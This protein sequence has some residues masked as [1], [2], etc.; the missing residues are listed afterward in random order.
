[1]L[2]LIDVIKKMGETVAKIHNNHLVHGDLTTSNFLLNESQQIVVIDWGLSFVSEKAED[3]A[4][5]LYV[6]ER[7]FNSTHPNHPELVYIKVLFKYNSLM[8]F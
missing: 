8:Y 6:L 5:D 2:E 3:K 1:M 4:V 7:A